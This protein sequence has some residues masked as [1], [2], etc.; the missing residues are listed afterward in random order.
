MVEATPSFGLAASQQACCQNDRI[1]C[2]SA[3]AAYRIKGEIFLFEQSIENAPG[4]GSQRSSALE[5]QRQVPF[6]WAR[7]GGLDG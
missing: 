1:H 2:S 7:W 5:R 6:L 4:K 3:R